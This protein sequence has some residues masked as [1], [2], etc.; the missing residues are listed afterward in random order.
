MIAVT[1]IVVMVIVTIIVVVVIAMIGFMLTAIAIEF[2]VGRRG[3]GVAGITGQSAN[4][5]MIRW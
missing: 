1:I 5:R 3:H 4:R 2:K